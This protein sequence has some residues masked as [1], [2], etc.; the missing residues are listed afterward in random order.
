MLLNKVGA[1]VI[2]KSEGSGDWHLRKVEKVQNMDS[3]LELWRPWR[4]FNLTTHFTQGFAKKH[5]F[6]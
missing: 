5:T 2:P 3:V 4:R 6:L 1:S